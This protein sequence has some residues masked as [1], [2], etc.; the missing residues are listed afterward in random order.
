MQAKRVQEIRPYSHRKTNQKLFQ[1]IAKTDIGNQKIIDVG[2]G[3]GYFLRL[4][5]EHL[6]KNLAIPPSQVLRGCDLY[7]ENFRYQEVTC[8]K[9]DANGDLPYRDSE[10]DTVC[11]VEV[12]EHIEDQ[13]HF[14]RELYRIAKPGGRVFVTTPNILN[15]NS[16]IRFMHSGFAQLFYPLPLSA[17]DPVHKGHTHPVSFYYLAYIFSYCGFREIK[18]HFDRTKKSAVAWIIFFY[19]PILICHCYF[20]FRMR[21]RNKK[22]YNENKLVLDKINSLNMLTSRTLIVEGVK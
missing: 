10:F 7:P 13:F 17:K 21:R 12:I 2:A 14:V 1:L 20:R 19:L 5:G 8:D 16:R 11:S 3:E 9:I 22:I 18:L 15:I 4:L 6:K